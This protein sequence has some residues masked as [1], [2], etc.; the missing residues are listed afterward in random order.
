MA[1]KIDSL[2]CQ[3]NVVYSEDQ[4]MDSLPLEEGQHRGSKQM[5]V[6]WWVH[7]P[8]NSGISCYSVAFWAQNLSPESPNKYLLLFSRSMFSHMGLKVFW[9]RAG[10]LWGP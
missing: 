2:G 4:I 3:V 6:R 9:G 7:G 8:L 10:V 5:R 1:R